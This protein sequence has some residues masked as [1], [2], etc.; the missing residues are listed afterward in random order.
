MMNGIK[1]LAEAMATGADSRS[2]TVI[3]S[4]PRVNVWAARFFVNHTTYAYVNVR[5]FANAYLQ[6]YWYVCPRGPWRRRRRRRR[7]WGNA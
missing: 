3:V 2:P 1:T 7:R 5:A 4:I 6:L